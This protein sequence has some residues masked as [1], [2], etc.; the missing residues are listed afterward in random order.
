MVRKHIWPDNVV[1]EQ[2]PA[3][4]ASCEV[5]LCCAKYVINNINTSDGVNVIKTEADWAA[6][7][8][9]GG[10]VGQ[11]AWWATTSNAEG[12]SGADREAHWPLA[13]G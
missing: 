9:P 6:W 12:G 10:P 8:L 5:V 4:L 3:A 1:R 11:P 13:I 2:K 7:Q